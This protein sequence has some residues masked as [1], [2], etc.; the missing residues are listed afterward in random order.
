MT[1]HLP[2]SGPR[3]RNE[4]VQGNLQVDADAVGFL[5]VRWFFF[6]S[7]FKKLL[8]K[9][10]RWALRFPRRDRDEQGRRFL[11]YYSTRRE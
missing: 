3:W 5:P 4:R 8:N 9:M 6:F 7:L 1:C 11:P 10:L 2:T